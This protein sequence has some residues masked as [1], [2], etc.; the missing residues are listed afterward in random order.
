LG[1]VYGQQMIG[2]F[3][4]HYRPLLYVLIA[5][6]VTVGIGALVY[7]K[8]YRPKAQREERE[9]GEEVQ[10]FPVPGR[11]PKDRDGGSS[12]DQQPAIVSDTLA[13]AP[14]PKEKP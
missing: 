2:F 5:L 4:Q 12:Q 3:S 10:N 1:R 7:F 14:K 11:H 13:A 6:A 8:W 9:R